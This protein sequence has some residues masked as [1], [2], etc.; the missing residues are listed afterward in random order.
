MT[1]E[2]AH[3]EPEVISSER[4][5]DRWLGLRVDYLRYPSGFE[6]A[7][8]VV[9]HHGGVTLLPI[10]AE[11]NVLFVT[12]YR[13]PVGR[14]LLELPAGTLDGEDPEVCAQRELQEE[15]GFRAD[16]IELLGGFYAAPSYSTE[17]LPVYLCTELIESRL[18]GDEESIEVVAIPL[19][20]A[21]AMVGAGEIE[22]AKTL[23]A[24]LLYQRRP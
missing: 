2:F 15:T 3:D 4:I 20:K 9:E 21:L 12:Q 22:D 8:D 23:A 10:D 7:H 13:H 17:Y 1:G 19:D 16:S 18:P 24:L 5:Y 14:V 6:M 11:G